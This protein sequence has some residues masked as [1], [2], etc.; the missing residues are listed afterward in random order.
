MIKKHTNKYNAY[1]GLKAMLLTRRSEYDAFKLVTDT[2]DEFIALTDEI[3]RVAS[4]ISKARVGLTKQKYKTKAL[5]AERTAAL[6][7]VGTLYAISI[8]DGTLQSE[9]KCNISWIKYAKD[10]EAYLRASGIEK[11]LRKNLKHLGNYL[12]SK[13]DLD[14]LRA[15]IEDYDSI[16][17]NRAGVH[18]DNIVSNRRVEELFDKTDDL[19]YNKLDRIIMRL[20]IE[21]EDFYEN[22]KQARKITDLK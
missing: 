8:G 22:Y 7:G 9:L 1:V 14:A 21:N 6:A 5:M 12:I 13:E 10:S 4:E 11:L 2:V 18:N 17:M 20:G 16:V 3:M 19:L 15:I